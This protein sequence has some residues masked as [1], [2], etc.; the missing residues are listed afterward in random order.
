MSFRAWGCWP[1]G[2]FW[3]AVFSHG[4]VLTTPPDNQP[5]ASEPALRTS[6]ELCSMLDTA[7]TSLARLFQARLEGRSS[8][9]RNSKKFPG[10]RVKF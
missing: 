5:Q 7:P 8:D 6:L 3:G 4:S 1:F 10:L 9:S 2:P